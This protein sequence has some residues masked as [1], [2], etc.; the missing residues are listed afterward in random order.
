MN[1][2]DFLPIAIIALWFIA[3][4]LYGSGRNPFDDGLDAETIQQ[5]I[6]LAIYVVFVFNILLIP[7]GIWFSIAWLLNTKY[8]RFLALVPLL[9]PIFAVVMVSQG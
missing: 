1:I 5:K 3:L 7:I 4:A 6:G 9:F 2:K 8:G